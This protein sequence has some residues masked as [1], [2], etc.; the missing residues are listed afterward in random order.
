[1]AAG[2]G[3]LIILIIIIFIAYRQ[4]SQEG[5]RVMKHMQNQMDILE[6]MVAK[7]CKEG[8]DIWRQLS[9]DYYKK[10]F[11]YRQRNICN[12]SKMN[13]YKHCHEWNIC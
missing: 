3:V 10:L 5:V 11:M 9:I 12:L 8:M 4:K 2:G 13:I 1:M 6:A 7:E